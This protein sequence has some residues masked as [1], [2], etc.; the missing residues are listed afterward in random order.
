[1]QSGDQKILLNLDREGV[2][3]QGYD[4]VA[5]FTEGKPVMGDSKIRSS[6]GGGVY[7]FASVS[8][9][10][11]FDANPAKYEP[12]FGGWCAYA[13]SINALSPIDPK[14]WEIVDGRLLLQHNQK[15][16]DL[17]HKDASGNLV[18][19]DKNWPGLVAKNGSPPRTL[20]NVDAEGLALEG[21]DPSSYFIDN[22]PIRG[23]PALA[24]T[25]QGATYYFVDT[26]HKNAFESNPAKFV[27]KFG[28]FCGYAASINK[29]S[30]VNPEIWQIVDGRLVLQHTPEAYRLFNQDVAASNAKAEQNW[31][32][33]VHRRCGG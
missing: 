30:P 5:Y 29:V 4:P 11:M 17:W 14:Y 22:K 6:H 21:Y 27:P 1:M 8:N 19:A 3:I 20:L 10:A 15:A 23:D 2:A 7:W 18:L 12:Q 31:P 26:A 33:L 16:W 25:Y 13:A 32:G 9:K 24:R 28:G